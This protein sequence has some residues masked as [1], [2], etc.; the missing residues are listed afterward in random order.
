M[1]FLIIKPLIFIVLF[2]I[3]SFSFA[4]NSSIE[5]LWRSFDND[6]QARSIV[7]FYK[8]GNEIKGKIV[9]VIPV[10]GKD[11][12]ICT[13]CT[14]ELKDKPLLGMVIVWGL[15][16]KGNEWADGTV[17]DTD[18]GTTYSCSATLSDDG[19]ILHFY[20]HLGPF[21]STIDW[22]RVDKIE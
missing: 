14:D 17:L 12:K 20:A 1:R 16:Q 9:K 18:S 4:Q 5:G 15:V 3:S 22:Q 13:Q 7:Q 21:G 11:D 2:T 10:G 6:K 8:E 19:K